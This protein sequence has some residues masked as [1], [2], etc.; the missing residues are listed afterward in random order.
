MNGCLIHHCL[1][2]LRLF[3]S[4]HPANLPGVEF[5]VPPASAALSSCSSFAICASISCCF[6]VTFR[7][8]SILHGRCAHVF[9]LDTFC[10]VRGLPWCF[11]HQRHRSAS[12]LC[13]PSPSHGS[14]G[15][16]PRSAL[17]AEH[18]KK[19]LSQSGVHLPRSFLCQHSW[20]MTCLSL[21]FVPVPLRG[22]A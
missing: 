13:L 17:H 14:P 21:P 19:P 20:A 18:T 7:S 4:S 16:L 1:R 15:L 3:P 9:S 5:V 12:V 11:H 8:N 2:Q 10:A 6:P 22:V